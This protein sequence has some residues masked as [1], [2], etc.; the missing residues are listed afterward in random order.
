MKLF[1]LVSLVSADPTIACD[2]CCKPEKYSRDAEVQCFERICISKNNAFIESA[3][4]ELV[5]ERE[6]DTDRFQRVFEDLQQLT[7]RMFPSVNLVY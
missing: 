2:Y 5:F 3:S 6:L 7:Y 1:L 4:D